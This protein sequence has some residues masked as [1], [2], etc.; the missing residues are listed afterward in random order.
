M[1]PPYRR[2]K[3]SFIHWGMTDVVIPRRAS[4]ARPEGRAGKRRARRL[5]LAGLAN[6]LIFERGAGRRFRGGGAQVLRRPRDL[7]A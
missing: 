7:V 3:R 5:T 4:T 6:R 2:A 1:E